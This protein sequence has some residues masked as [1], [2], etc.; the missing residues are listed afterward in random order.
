MEQE[1]YRVKVSGVK[2]PGVIGHSSTK[3]GN[4]EAELRQTD[5]KDM[6]PFW[7]LFFFFKLRE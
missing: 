4:L 3:T 6:V 2:R 5:V 7:C 1:L